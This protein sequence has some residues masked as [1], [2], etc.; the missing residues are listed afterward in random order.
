MIRAILT[1]AA[2]AALTAGVAG[3]AHAQDSA[4]YDGYCYVRSADM[5][6]NNSTDSYGNQRATARCMNGE[7]YVY[8]D[9]YKA[10]P[11]APRGYQIEYFTHRPSKDVY[12]ALYNASTLTQNFD[13]GA[14]NRFNGGG[15]SSF[16]S[17]YA[18]TAAQYNQA[19]Q[20]QQYSQSQYPPSSDNGY[21]A[22]QNYSNGYAYNTDSR[23]YNQ[24]AYSDPQPGAVDQDRSGDQGYSNSDDRGYGDR[25][26][27]TG[28]RDENGQWHIGKPAAFGWRDDNGR[29]HVGRYAAAGWQDSDGNWH[30][31]A[32]GSD[33]NSGNY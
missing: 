9:S 11:A 5:A 1:T 22:G 31:N 14:Q 17:D 33:G 3:A 13:P 16:N 32:A 23:G 10:A 18:E 19:Q 29:W 21:N 6:R 28:W 12:G 15:Q 2:L 30:E 8:T 27:T 24:S 26:R 25:S 4:H 7:Y 20:S